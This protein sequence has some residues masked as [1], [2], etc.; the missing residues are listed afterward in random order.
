[1]NRDGSTHLNLFFG[2]LCVIEG[3]FLDDEM[4]DE[5]GV[6]EER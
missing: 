6:G 5:V 3:L 1:M 2:L 4:E